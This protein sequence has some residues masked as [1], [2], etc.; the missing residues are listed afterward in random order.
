MYT[1]NLLLVQ[2]SQNEGLD[3]L[4]FTSMKIT[5]LLEKN[6]DIK[7]VFETSSKKMSCELT[8]QRSVACLELK[9]S[10]FSHS[11]SMLKFCMREPLV[12]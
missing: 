4:P 5:E 11:D 7:S 6:E 9:Q 12:K 1:Y 2:F 8:A 10:L 3:Q